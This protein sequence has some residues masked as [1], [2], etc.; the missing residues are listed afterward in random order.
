MG[1]VMSRERGLLCA[2]LAVLHA[3]A[4]VHAQVPARALPRGPVP[5]KSLPTDPGPSRITRSFPAGGIR[6]VVLRAEAAERAE[7]V[8][9][10]GG[11]TVT[12]SGVPEGGAAGYHPA[13]PNWRETPASRWGL[14]FRAKAFGPTL[15]I[16]SSAEISYIHHHYH[17][18]RIRIAVPQGVKVIKEN[19]QLTG[20][21]APDLA[22]PVAR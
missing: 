5:G 8:T 15:V 12:V 11:R 17:L 20:E 22:E 21:G 13:D 4:E 1:I 19:R 7:V 3:S 10:P 14:D 6:T 18:D 9:L 2:F 16:S